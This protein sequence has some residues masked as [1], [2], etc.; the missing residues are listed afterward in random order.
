IWGATFIMVKAALTDIDPVIMVAYRFLIAGGKLAVY[1]LYKK[2]NLWVYLGRSFM[3]AVL[4]WFL[5]VP[6]TMGLKYTTAS[7]SGFITGLFVAF[8][9]LF[10]RTL[11]KRRPN[12]MEITASLISLA[13]LW[14]L[15]GG[16]TDIN[17]GD[18]LTLSAAMTYALHLLYSDRY[19]KA[20]ADPLLISCQQF[21]LVGVMCLL[22]GLVF[23][24]PF[25]VGSLKAG[26]I[27]LFL[28]LFPTLTA[29]V[30]QMLAQKITSPLRVSLIFALEPVFAALFAWT[31]GGETFVTHRA[32]GG[33]LI[34][35]ALILSGLPAPHIKKPASAA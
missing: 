29:F 25:E 8:V 4:L 16:L 3:L 9:P 33:L 21:L 7:N 27:V 20:G 34:F 26:A 1:M 17:I 6:Q 15:T 14:F 28:A 13:G 12:V 11:F 24:L 2:R 22:T 5:Y 10:M 32:F 18:I 23:D 19:M 31:L 35:A 30:I